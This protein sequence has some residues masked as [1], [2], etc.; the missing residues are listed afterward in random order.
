MNLQGHG[1]LRRRKAETLK[2]KG[3]R[4]LSGERAQRVGEKRRHGCYLRDEPLFKG[5]FPH[6]RPETPRKVSLDAHRCTQLMT[7]G[8]GSP[9]SYSWCIGL[10]VRR[11]R[12]ATQGANRRVSSS[13]LKA[14]VLPLTRGPGPT[15]HSPWASVSVCEE[16]GPPREERTATPLRLRRNQQPSL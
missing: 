3:H 13:P 9:K 11:R 1:K 5:R 8:S 16:G 6:S 2:A 12:T 15:S 10:R 7:R 4:E 14:A